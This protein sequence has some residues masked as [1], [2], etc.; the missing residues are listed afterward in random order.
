MRMPQH[1]SRRRRPVRQVQ[2][3]LPRL[4]TMEDRVLLSTILVNTYADETTANDGQTSLREAIAEAS[5]MSG[6]MTVI[7][8][9]GMYN[10][11]QGQLE[12]NDPNGTL[13]IESAGGQAVVNGQALSRDV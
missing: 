6:P 4:E 13:T 12:I 5:T 8:P 7:V 11:A 3:L 2:S 9:A 10:L 1:V